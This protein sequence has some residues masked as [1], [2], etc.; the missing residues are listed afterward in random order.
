VHGQNVLLRENVKLAP[1]THRKSGGLAPHF[2]DHRTEWSNT[3]AAFDPGWNDPRV[4]RI[5]ILNVAQHFGSILMRGVPVILMQYITVN[6]SAHTQHFITVK[7]F[8][9]CCSMFSYSRTIS[10]FIYFL[11]LKPADGAAETRSFLCH[12][13]RFE[14]TYRPHPHCQITRKSAGLI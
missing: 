2:L 12:Y 1:F 4:P 8:S 7:T 6:Q 11:N 5:Q 14:T 10:F 13:R 9:F 3:P